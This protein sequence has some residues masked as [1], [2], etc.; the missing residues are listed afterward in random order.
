MAAATDGVRARIDELN[1]PIALVLVESWG[2]LQDS[3][4]QDALFDILRTDAISARYQVRT[5][6]L[7]FRGGTTSG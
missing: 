2:V 1:T 7:P 6:T 3:A 4:A 5:G